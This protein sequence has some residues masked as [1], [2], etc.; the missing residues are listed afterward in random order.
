MSDKFFADDEN[1][2]VDEEVVES[3]DV[4][5][6]VVDEAAEE[7]AEEI[8]A[9]ADEEVGIKKALLAERDKRQKLE[10]ERDFLKGQ[11]ELSKAVPAPA[12]KEVEAEPE[13]DFLENPDES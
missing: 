9:P 6:E 4:G 11:L 12:T 2:I 13:L 5:D 8:V 10:W 3:E 1:E 7:V